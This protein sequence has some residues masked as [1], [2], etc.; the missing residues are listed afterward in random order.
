MIDFGA[1]PGQVT[2]R[3]RLPRESL[4]HKSANCI[5]GTVLMASLL[6]AASL[7]AAIVLVPGHAFVGW[8]TW[9]GTD[10]WDYLETTMIAT[11]D[12]EAA[13][14]RART[15][16]ER[17]AAEDLAERRR[18]DPP[19]AEAQRPPG[20]GHLADGMS[21]GPARSGRSM[22]LG[23]RQDGRPDGVGHLGPGEV[24]VRPDEHPLVLADDPAALQVVDPAR[25]ELV[26]R[27]RR[28]RSPTR[29]GRPSPQRPKPPTA[30]YLGSPSPEVHLPATPAASG[31]QRPTA[32]SCSDCVVTIGPAHPAV[33]TT[34][35]K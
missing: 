22:N 34:A 16:F 19:R 11:H 27:P 13:G 6:E 1:G 3:T 30:P 7:H 31:Y 17:F 8:E 29:P 14:Q 25:L 5:D 18:P 21:A 24:A 32:T 35:W 33:G 2:Q 20:P 28:P 4:R 26:S 15:L 9:P 12:F 10:E 23:T